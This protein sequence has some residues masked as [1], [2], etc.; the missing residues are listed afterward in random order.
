MNF[1]EL[2]KKLLEDTTVGYGGVWGDSP[3]IGTHGGDFKCGDWFAKGNAM[4][5]YGDDL[6]KKGKKRRKKFPL[7]RRKF[8][9]CINELYNPSG[10]P[11]KGTK[12]DKNFSKNQIKFGASIEQDK[13]M[14]GKMNRDQARQFALKNLEGDNQFYDKKYKHPIIHPGRT[15]Q[16][17][18][19]MR[20]IPSR[21]SNRKRQA[22]QSPV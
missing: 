1:S 20:T 11:V 14:P 12:W 13:A 6:T 2:V 16:W 7:Y 22:Q 3:A 10:I 4:N 5:V 9:E 8:I 15:P 19:R 17:S 21:I 18:N